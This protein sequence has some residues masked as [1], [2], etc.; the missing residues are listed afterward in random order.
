MVNT[1]RSFDIKKNESASKI[2]LR[3]L[4]VSVVCDQVTV[5]LFYWRLHIT[6]PFLLVF[7]ENVIVRYIFSTTLS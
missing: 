2:I 3:D 7:I 5:D 4:Y 1:L 6:F